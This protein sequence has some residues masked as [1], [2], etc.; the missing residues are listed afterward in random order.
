MQDKQGNID[1]QIYE[2]TINKVTIITPF[3]TISTLNINRL[4]SPIKRYRM[5][6]CRNKKQNQQQTVCCL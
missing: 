3:L 4:N 2:K 1:L 6:G 5:T